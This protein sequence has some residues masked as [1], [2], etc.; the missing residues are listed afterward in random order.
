M[1][2]NWWTEGQIAYGGAADEAIVRIGQDLFI[3]REGHCETAFRPLT[4]TNAEQIPT[5]P[6]GIGI[7]HF[8]DPVTGRTATLIAECDTVTVC[9]TMSTPHTYIP[10]T[11]SRRTKARLP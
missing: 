3:K 10:T 11:P 6:N 7:L 5:S 4:V 1:F 8:E 9:Y 2:P